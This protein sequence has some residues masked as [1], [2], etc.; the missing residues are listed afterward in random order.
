MEQKTKA[1][2]RAFKDEA[3]GKWGFK[4]SNDEVVVSPIYRNAYY[5]FSEGLCPVVDEDKKF[6]FVDE[7]GKL[8]IPCKFIHALDFRDGLASVQEEGTFKNGYINHQGELV[9]PFMYR[10][11]G[12][13]ING[14]AMVSDDSGRWGAIN[15]ENELVYPIQYG[16]EELYDMLYKGK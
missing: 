3:S 5:K 9:I 10:K 12:D 14:L 2:L 7:T 8:V 6:G 13:F 15:H 16:W 11:G 4:N 1:P